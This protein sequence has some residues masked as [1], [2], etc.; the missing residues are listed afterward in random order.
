MILYDD[1]SVSE[2]KF[3]KFGPAITPTNA[4]STSEKTPI[5]AAHG[6]KPPIAKEAKKFII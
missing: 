1:Y 6:L 3:L 4:N 5:P 2:S